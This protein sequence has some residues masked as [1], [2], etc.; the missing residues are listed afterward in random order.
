M[1][2]VAL[3]LILALVLAGSLPRIGADRP[4]PE[5]LQAYLHGRALLDQRIAPALEQARVDFERA[6][7]I[8]PRYAEAHAGIADSYLQRI[9]IGLDRPADLY[10]HA[11]AAAQRALALDPDLAEARTTL[12]MVFFLADHDFPRGEQEIR[13]ALRSRPDDA[14][15]HRWYAFVLACSGRRSEAVAEARRALSLAPRDLTIHRDVLE[16]FLLARDYEA[17]VRQ[18][19]RTLELAPDHADARLKVAWALAH[20]GRDREAYAAFRATLR[21]VGVT[22]RVLE[23]LDGVFA[24]EGLPGLYRATARWMEGAA[25]V[26]GAGSWIDLAVL[27]AAAG[28]RDRA[29]AWIERGVERQDPY[30]VLFPVSPL[31]DGLRSDPRF[32]RLLRRLGMSVP[33][34]SFP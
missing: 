19:K 3:L 8:H 4:P 12:A 32:P 18:G 14:N 34:S 22:P 6:L 15:A 16:V 23:N 27:Y 1:A 20:Q 13:R 21:S 26:L 31:I 2:T 10:P 5:A 7:E 11:R 17:V 25:P 28:D 9:V 33:S 29:F 30:L 24:A